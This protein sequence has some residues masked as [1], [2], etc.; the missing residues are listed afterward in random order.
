[1]RRA[2]IVILVLL[3]GCGRP[4]APEAVRTVEPSLPAAVSVAP[5]LALPPA[6]ELRTTNY[7][8]VPNSST[9][10]LECEVWIDGVSVAHFR[11]EN[12]THSLTVQKIDDS[13]LLTFTCYKRDLNITY[14]VN[15]DVYKEGRLFYSQTNFG[16]AGATDRE[17]GTI[18]QFYEELFS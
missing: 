3:S 5:R 4:Q 7:R 9:G 10:I 18:E 6:F 17:W 15:F 2:C 12:A 11:D 8:G 13:S 14:F 16:G 1:M